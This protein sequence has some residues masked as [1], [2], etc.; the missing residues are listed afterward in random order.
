M[1][2]KINKSLYAA[3]QQI[4]RPLA[5][6]L[7]RNGVAYG[8]FAALARQVYVDIAYDEFAPEGRKQTVSRVSALTGLTRKEVKRL[9]EL[10]AAPVTE[11]Q[12][13]Y[14]RGV[15][16][17]IGWMNDKEFHDGKGKP[18]SLPID[19]SY[20]SFTAL[21]KKYSGDIPVRAMQAML[22]EG[23]T[24]AVQ[25]GTVRLIRHAYVPGRDDLGKIAILGSDVAN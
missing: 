18:A 20:G 13:R 19:G 2:E 25:D 14:S 11:G 24:I 7:L 5:R 10:E 9:L 6:I 15:R 3:V 4:L 17:F 22:V 23:G 1:S 16:V 12:A 8:T 21:V